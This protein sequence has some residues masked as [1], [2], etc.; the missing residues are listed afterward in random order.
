MPMR[1][2]LCSQS[3]TGACILNQSE[4]DSRIPLPIL[5]ALFAE[6]VG[7][8]EVNQIVQEAARRQRAVLADVLKPS[9]RTGRT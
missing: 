9:Q 4:P 2:T 6:R 3:P 5:S 7:A 8:V 1:Q